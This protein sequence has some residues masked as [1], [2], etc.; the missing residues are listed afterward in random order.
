VL[1]TYRS[2]K[3]HHSIP[4]RERER[5]IER[6]GE[7]ERQRQTVSFPLLKTGEL[8]EPFGKERNQ[9]QSNNLK[10]NTLEQK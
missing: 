2:S 6:D 4:E 8:K 1:I 10:F 9:N 3:I 7:R 5:K